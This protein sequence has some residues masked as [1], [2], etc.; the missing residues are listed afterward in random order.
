MTDDYSGVLGDRRWFGRAERSL[1]A[2]GIVVAAIGG[3][4]PLLIALIVVL[5]S[6][7]LRDF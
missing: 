7:G 1:F 5:Y 2:V 3:A 6:V 4:I